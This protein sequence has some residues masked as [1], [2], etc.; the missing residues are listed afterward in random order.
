MDYKRFPSSWGS[1]GN[2]F[3]DCPVW[4]GRI[5]QSERKK[6]TMNNKTAL[7]TPVSTPMELLP[8]TPPAPPVPAG[9]RTATL[10]SPRG[11]ACGERTFMGSKSAG[12]LRRAGKAIGLKGN[13]L[14]EWV[15]R[16]LTNEKASR[17]AAVAATV[18]ALDSA[19]YVADV[20][21][22][23][24]ASATIK[25]VKPVAPKVKPVVVAPDVSALMDELEKLRAELAAA[26]AAKA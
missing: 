15:N 8:P 16:A 10:L 12:E 26:L 24:K 6:G 14:S 1:P 13:G 22:I 9:P 17:A 23:R 18:S 20:A 2:G 19:G 3:G 5:W 21:D 11:K 7:K 25:F 4:D